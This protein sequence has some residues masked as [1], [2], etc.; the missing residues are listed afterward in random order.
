MP[1]PRFYAAY[2]AFGGRLDCAQAPCR[3]AQA[4]DFACAVIGLRADDATFDIRRVCAATCARCLRGAGMPRKR[5]GWGAIL[6]T[7]ARTLERACRIL[8]GPAQ[9]AAHLNVGEAELGPWLEGRSAPPESV[10]L[11]ALEIV[12]LDAD[13]GPAPRA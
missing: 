7:Y 4:P 12:L 13:A 9:L 8:G 10:F 11:A 5:T 6:P 3:R 1:H 2:K